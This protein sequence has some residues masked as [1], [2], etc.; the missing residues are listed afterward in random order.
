MHNSKLPPIVPLVSEPLRWSRQGSFEQRA[1]LRRDPLGTQSARDPPSFSHG[2]E[3]SSG[4]QPFQGESNA[5]FLTLSDEVSKDE[6]PTSPTPCEN[7]SPHKRAQANWYFTQLN[8]LRRELVEM[9]DLHH[10]A[11]DNQARRHEIDLGNLEGRFEEH[12]G[13]CQAHTCQLEKRNA[14]LEEM[15]RALLNECLPWISKARVDK[16]AC[17]IETTLLREQLYKKKE[18]SSKREVYSQRDK[19]GPQLILGAVHQ[20]EDQL[21]ESLSASDD[22]RSE[23]FSLQRGQE[24]SLPS[25]EGGLEA[26]GVFQRED[27]SKEHSGSNAHERYRNKTEIKC[28]PGRGGPKLDKGTIERMSD[29]L[30]ASRQNEL[31]LKAAI[32]MKCRFCGDLVQSSDFYLHV[33]DCQVDNEE[34]FISNEERA[35]PHSLLA[36]TNE[37]YDFTLQ[38]GSRPSSPDPNPT[39]PQE[40]SANSCEEQEE[41]LPALGYKMVSSVFPTRPRGDEISWTGKELSLA[42]VPSYVNPTESS[43][44]SRTAAK[45]ES[46]I[47]APLSTIFGAS[48]ENATLEGTS[49]DD[50]STSLAVNKVNL[51]IERTDNLSSV[52][53][54][55]DFT[56]ERAKRLASASI[57]IADSPPSSIATPSLS[58]S[59]ETASA[60]P[61]FHWGFFSL[62]GSSNN[63][64]QSFAHVMGG[65]KHVEPDSPWTIENPLSET[66]GR[67]TLK[68]DLI[69]EEIFVAD[70]FTLSVPSTETRV[71]DQKRSFTMYLIIVRIAIAGA[72]TTGWVVKR[73]YKEFLE[74]DKEV[75]SSVLARFYFLQLQGLLPPLAFAGIPHP[76]RSLREASQT[77][78]R[79]RQGR[80]EAYLSAMVGIKRARVST[81]LRTFLDLDR[82]K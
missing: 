20:T 19:S 18:I 21:A 39:N 12:L 65:R 22:A 82:P 75:R 1:Q 54:Q 41:P 16:L 40:E 77:E 74:L 67:S 37:I 11:L 9:E 13:D 38:V 36:Q 73:R 31:L 6:F 7:V 49:H 51:T 61:T 26:D 32:M 47:F 15:N 55:A 27:Q 69:K 3:D 52:S 42:S 44:I 71:D 5:S 63:S 57:S 62:A 80:L 59:N 53:N 17:D 45:V 81:P 30:V 29:Y 48:H 34:E 78:V 64:P 70:R 50:A 66:H 76:H 2:P 10:R 68:L 24:C 72:P 79:R 58:P 33:V 46:S 4:K 43:L 28:S 23:T 25:K 35:K 56:V 14:F 60:S 8:T